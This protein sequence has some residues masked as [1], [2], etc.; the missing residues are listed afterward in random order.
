MQTW[1][2]LPDK[3]SKANSER[4][5]VGCKYNSLL[6]KIPNLLTK[7]TI[8]VH[9]KRQCVTPHLQLHHHHHH[10]SLLQ[11]P[12]LHRRHPPPLHQTISHR[13]HHHSMFRSTSTPMSFTTYTS[14]PFLFGRMQSQN[15][16]ITM[17]SN[18]TW[19]PSNHTIQTIK[20]F[21]RPNY[22]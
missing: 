17:H 6:I 21:F 18:S 16:T 4:R 15:Q 22:P 8:G 13:I 2:A 7:M 11:R 10:H 12:H 1:I 3:K 14:L 20:F 19:G 5:L 9:K